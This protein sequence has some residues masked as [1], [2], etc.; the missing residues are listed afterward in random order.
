MLFQHDQPKAMWA[1]PQALLFKFLFENEN[2]E[3]NSK[4]MNL[5]KNKINK[6]KRNTTLIHRI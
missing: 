4:I 3:I 5:K 6:N 2:T 1:F